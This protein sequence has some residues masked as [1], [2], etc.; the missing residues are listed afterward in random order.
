MILEQAAQEILDIFAVDHTSLI[1]FEPVTQVGYV[2]AEQPNKGAQGLQFNLLTDPLAQHLLDRQVI[3]I[4]DVATDARLS[5]AFR[6]RLASMSIHAMVVTPLVSQFQTVGAFTLDFQLPR[7]FTPDEL[8]LCQTIA[9]QV[10]VALTNA[11][12]ARELETRVATRTK[13]LQRERERVE[14]LL[15][16]TT[17]LSS[18]LDLDRVLARALQL[19][20]EAV[21][22]TQGSI[23]LIDLQTDQLMYRAALGSPKVL[24][25]GGEPAPFKKGE[26]LVG[27]V[28]K[29]RQAVVINDLESD[30]RWKKIP[31]Q[32]VNHRSAMAVPLLWNEDVLGAILLFSPAVNAFDEEQLRLVTAAANQVG[33]ASN[34]AELYRLI[35]DQA[36][37]LGNLLRAQ[38]VET[39][40]NRAILEGIADGVL[41]ADADGQ[42]ILFNAACERILGLRRDEIMGRPIT[43]YVG[44]YGAQ[45]RAWIDSI[46]RWSLD[47]TTYSPGDFATQRLELA[48][49]RVLSVTLAP[50]MTGDEYLGSVSLIRDITRE[51]EIDRMK[52]QIITHV[53]HELRTPLTPAKGWTDMLL[54]GAGGPLSPL[55]KQ[56]A[57]V[58]KASIDRLTTL[59]D[60]MLDISR[61]ESTKAETVLGPTNPQVVVA[62]ALQTLQ[63]EIEAM[64]KTMN[65]ETEVPMDLPPILA[66]QDKLVQAL[67]KLTDNA[68]NYTPESGTITLRARLDESQHEVHFEVEDTGS[69]IA[70]EYQP[71]LF[72]KF[73]RGE[74]NPLVMANAGTGLGLSIAKQ[75]I[76]KQN[77]RL[78][79]KRT[80]EGQGSTFAIALPVAE[81]PA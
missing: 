19:V 17:E 3:T 57:E 49:K 78:W 58:I 36:E 68:L 23:F 29:N 48:D 41:V 25:P 60:D 51:V 14:T 46:T 74:K 13:E 44:I 22:A 50:V 31:G 5:E 30:T 70:E 12:F 21:H 20:T 45:G 52:S 43:E 32:N 26:G 73:F 69:G 81:T 6:H 15:Q 65:V 54:L 72:D 76:E 4:D 64:R 63:T 7:Q 80:Q 10:A 34:N 37:R 2:E 47:P 28:I 11:Q 1:V 67:N 39:T 42:V 59:V 71:M 16:I 38:Q 24:L 75:L 35:R 27:W 18:S 77:G 8:E 79:L 40:K 56:A 33:S 9:A 53:S 55:Q 62:A 61:I 66:D